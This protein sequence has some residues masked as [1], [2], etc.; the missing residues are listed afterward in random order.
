ML[1]KIDAALLKSVQVYP[2][3]GVFHFFRLTKGDFS[4]LYA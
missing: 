2:F 1:I 4:L 3:A